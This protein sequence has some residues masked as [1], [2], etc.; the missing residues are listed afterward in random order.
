MIETHCF[1]MTKLSQLRDVIE[2]PVCIGG[3]CMYSIA[4]L[5]HVH[6]KN[7]AVFL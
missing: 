5:Y 4:D 6:C 7:Y 1:I 3:Q 2:V